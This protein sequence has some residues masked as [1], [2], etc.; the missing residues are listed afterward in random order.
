MKFQQ[1]GESS[2]VAIKHRMMSASPDVFSQHF[3]FY[4][5]KV[6]YVRSGHLSNMYSQRIFG[7]ISPEHLLTVLSI[8]SYIHRHLADAFVPSDLQ[9]FIHTFI[10]WWRWLPCKVPTSTSG[11]VLGSVSWPGTVLRA[12][13]NHRPSNNKTL[14]LPLSHSHPKSLL[15]LTQLNRDVVETQFNT[16]SSQ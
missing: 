5:L 4:Y 11:A 10:H 13:S 3:L 9:W 8:Q 7:S 14:A 1:S 6:H 2:V 12:E 16:S 15:W